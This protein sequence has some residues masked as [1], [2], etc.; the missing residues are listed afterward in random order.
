MQLAWATD[1]HLDHCKPEALQAFL[2]ALTAAQADALCLTGDLSEAPQLQAHLCLLAEHLQKPV[3]FVLG[4]HDYYHGSIAEV[5]QRMTQLSQQ[6]PWLRWLPAAGLVPLSPES[7]LLGHDCWGD[8]RNGNLAQSWIKMTDF[9]LISE[10]VKAGENGR[11]ALLHRLG[12][13]GADYLRPLLYQAL[14]EFRQVW[15]LMH[16]PPLRE[17]CLYG[18]EV[19]DDHWA[20]Y[21]TCKAAGD[22]LLEVLPQYP[23]TQLTVLAGHTHNVC[24]LQ[25]LP[26]LRIKVG[27]ADY[28]QPTLAEL[29]SIA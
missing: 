23:Q 8:G 9:R 26:N 15:L 24:D 14:S 25:A 12:D 19:A 16:P 2:E 3:Y 28:G 22:L 7:C 10:F 18:S 20:P 27:L 17:A 11:E 1:I 29:L 6:H 21:F 13:E 5:R 4:N